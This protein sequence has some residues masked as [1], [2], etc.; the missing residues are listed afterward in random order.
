MNTNTIFKK[1]KLPLLMVSLLVAGFSGCAT[2]ETV[3]DK[4]Y[5]KAM[6]RQNE[7]EWKRQLQNY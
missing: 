6:D 3:T 7:E 4:D 5:I 2:S 1:M